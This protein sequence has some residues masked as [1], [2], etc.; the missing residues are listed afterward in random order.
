MVIELKNTVDENATIKSA[1]N[2]LETI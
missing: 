2:Q 1:Y